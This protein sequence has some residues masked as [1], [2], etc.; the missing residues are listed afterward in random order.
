[1]LSLRRP[2]LLC[3]LFLFLCSGPGLA[4]F[5]HPAIPTALEE[6]LKKLVKESQV[7]ETLTLYTRPNEFREEH[8]LKY[9]LPATKGGVEMSKVK[10]S[11]Q[12]LLAKGWHYGAESRL[13]RFEFRYVKPLAADAIEIGTTEAWFVPVYDTAGNRVTG[14]SPNLGYP[15]TYVLKQVGNAWLIASS[16]T[17]RAKR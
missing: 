12:G 1:M 9:W 7:F 10:S 11:I 8:L 13:E 14:R 17:P 2:A 16:S 5:Q 3:F 6:Q 4:L 15:V